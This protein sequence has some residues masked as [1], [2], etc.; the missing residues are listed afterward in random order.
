MRHGLYCLCMLALCLAGFGITPSL[1]PAEKETIGTPNGTV[2]LWYRTRVLEL[3]LDMLPWEQGTLVDS[4]VYRLRDRKNRDMLQYTYIRMSVTQASDEILAFYSKR[5]GI[6]VQRTTNK[7]TGEIMLFSGTISDCRIVTLTPGTQDAHLLLQRVKRFPI[8]PRE[9][10]AREQQIIR[11]LDEV[12]DTY[13]SAQH[14][15]YTIDQQIE[16]R[17]ANEKPRQMTPIRW[18]VD[19]TRP[20]RLSVTAM[21][22]QVTGLSIATKNGVLV[23]TRPG[24]PEET[25]P[26]GDALT[27]DS[28]P[29]LQDD[30][31]AR[32]M[33]GDS[34]ISPEVDY[35]T[36]LPTK[37]EGMKVVLTFPE[38]HAVLHLYLDLARKL[39][40]RSEIVMTVET[41]QARSNRRYSYLALEHA[42]PSPP[43]PQTSPP[44]AV[45][46]K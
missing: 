13:C 5:L 32:M 34:L 1:P 38:Q 17:E 40:T 27:I 18:T 15:A 2:M 6:N 7:D 36:L 22:Q 26:I 29:E 9:Y 21:A 23:V 4:G 8:P 10:T 16:T 41:S 45:R 31:V 42:V 37:D 44:G 24:N 28:A 35:L 14:V 12:A 19:F 39:I 25:R 11:L 43:Q 46:G 3:D 30:P 20:T 33:L